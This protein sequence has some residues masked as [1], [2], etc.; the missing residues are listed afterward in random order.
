M[1]GNHDSLIDKTFN[2]LTIISFS[3][4]DKRNGDFYVCRCTCGRT[5]KPIRLRYI[6]TG[7]TRS[8]GCLKDK[9][10]T[11]HGYCRGYTKVPEYRVWRSMLDRCYNAMSKSYRHYGGRGIA[12]C[13]Q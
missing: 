11:K 3:H 8:C 7:H 5:T 10:V 6:E 9:S 12:V 2:Q 1:A 13:D 4:R